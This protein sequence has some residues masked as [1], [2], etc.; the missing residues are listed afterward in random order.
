[1]QKLIHTTGRLLLLACAATLA[2][3]AGLVGPREVEVPLAKLQAGL[4]KRFPL[5]NRLMELFDVQLTHPLVSLQPDSGRV[6]LSMDASVAP[7]FVRQSWRGAMALS[8]RLYIDAARGAV[9]MA[10]PRLDRFAIEGIDAARQQQFQKAA[11]VLMR[12]VATDLPI[13]HFKMEDLRYAG[14][15][16]V[17]TRIAA[18]SSGLRVTVEPVK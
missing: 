14:V 1:M 10:E 4:D 16:F 7:P 11:N 18:T 6:G 15:Q 9:L 12:E 5:N 8:G 17:P 13:Y 3:C 2:S